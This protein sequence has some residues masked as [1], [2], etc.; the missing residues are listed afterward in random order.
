MDRANA[1][2]AIKVINPT[3]NPVFNPF[4]FFSILS[5]SSF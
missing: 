1:G 3:I 5:S 2:E 4:I